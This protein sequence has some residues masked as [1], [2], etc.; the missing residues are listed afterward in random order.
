MGSRRRARNRYTRANATFA[1]TWRNESLP[2][3][4]RNFAEHPYYRGLGWTQVR[5]MWTSFYMGHY[6]PLTWMTLGLD[7]LLW[8]MNPLGYHLTN[9]LLH[10]ANAGI[11]Y[12]VVVWLLRL[13]LSLPP[14]RDH[15][16]TFS[17]G[18]AALLFAV[19]PLRVE[20]VAWVTER[21][22]LL[23][24]FFY[25]LTLLAFLRSCERSERSRWHYWLSVALFGCALLSKSMAVS[26]PAVLL[27]LDVYPLRRLGGSIGWWTKPARRIYLEKVPFVLLAGVAS[28][29]AFKGQA[30]IHNMAPLTRFPMPHRLAVSAYGLAFYLLKTIVPSSLSPLYELPST[31]NPGEM[32]FILSYAAV[33]ALTAIALALRHRVPGMAAAWLAYVVCLLPV[34]GIFQNGP[35]IAADRYTYLAGLGWAILAGGGIVFCCRSSIRSELV[36]GSLAMCVVAALAVLTWKQVQVWHDS[37]SL[38]THALSIDPNSSFARNNLGH[39]LIR[40]SRLG[41]ALRHF[42][43]SLRT[44]PDDPLNHNNS[45]SVLLQQGRWADAEAH[46]NWGLA[47]LGQG[48]PTSAIEQFQQALRIAPNLVAA[49]S[50]WGTALIQQGKPAEAIAHFQI[51]LAIQPDLADTHI[52]WGA[53]LLQQGRPAEAIEYFRQ[54][55][56]I[57]PHSA[58][59]H[60]NWGVALLQLGKRTEATEHFQQAQRIERDLAETH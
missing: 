28:A 35:H 39:E 54:A 7:Y 38:W 55:A 29:V 41:D 5:W 40:Q 11:F 36:V 1:H 49:H 15:A 13:A 27:I 20:S 21:R 25:L 22:D 60:T 26:L 43:Q 37:E 8:G 47:L 23:S 57:A 42:E 19:H 6:M 24:G 45:G 10:A 14:E 32:R 58:P 44:R 46:N 17:A 31:M 9:L 59:A 30:V 53:A 3:D 33:L 56:R 12:F 2:D 51:A 18:L 4:G 34:L 52:N 16:L 50:N 48:N